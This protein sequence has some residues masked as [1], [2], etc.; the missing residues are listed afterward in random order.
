MAVQV[1]R[2]GSANSEK[3]EIND[4][5][6]RLWQWFPAVAVVEELPV[7]VQRILQNT[8]SCLMT[9]PCDRG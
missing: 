8:T 6:D 1:D 4:V 7:T 9:P 2:G 3:Y 5:L